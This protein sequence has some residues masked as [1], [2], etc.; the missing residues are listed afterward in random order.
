ME[1]VGEGLPL[2]KQLSTEELQKMV[3][4]HR[5]NQLFTIMQTLRTIKVNLVLLDMDAP[6]E[7]PI[8]EALR[9]EFETCA[10]LCIPK[11]PTMPSPPEGTQ[12]S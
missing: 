9:N 12:P 1:Q 8:A 7:Q 5:T 10:A 11:P 3:T 4:H 6:L 2:N